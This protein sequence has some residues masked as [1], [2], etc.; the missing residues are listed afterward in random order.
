MSLPQ[1][2][3]RPRIDEL[4]EAARRILLALGEDLDREGLRETPR[5]IAKS[6]LDLTSGSDVDV[7]GLALGALYPHEGDEPV[8]VRDIAFYSLCEHH[9]LP[10]FGT[11]HIGYL[12]SGQVLGLSKLPRIVD[13]YSHRLQMQERLTREIAEV[14]ED[15]VDAK[16]V[17]VVMQARHLCM[18]MRGVEKGS[19]ETVTSCMLGAYRTDAQLRAEFTNLVQRVVR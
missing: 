19:S 15:L 10:F 16:G 4:E 3:D 11:C 7:Y 6:L 14:I 1:P 2:S 17:A 9:L 18:E 5:R 13:A 8:V 12:P